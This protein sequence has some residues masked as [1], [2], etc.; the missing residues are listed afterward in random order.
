MMI[1]RLPGFVATLRLPF[2]PL[3]KSGGRNI[4]KGA[5]CD[6]VSA[7]AIAKGY[8]NNRPRAVI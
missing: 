2:Y 5:S 6:T 1:P 4:A 3:P 8:G 7:P